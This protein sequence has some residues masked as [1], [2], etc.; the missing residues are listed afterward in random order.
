MPILPIFSAATEPLS[1]FAGAGSPF[2][3]A[4]LVSST[5]LLSAGP[6]LALENGDF[7]YT[8]ARQLLFSYYQH[9]LYTAPCPR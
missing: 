7:G 4:A 6:A 8:I 2:S 3:I 9:G 1:A 5:L